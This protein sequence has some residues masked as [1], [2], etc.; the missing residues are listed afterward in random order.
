MV[1]QQHRVWRGKA[2]DER[3]SELSLRNLPTRALK[4]HTEKQQHHL[5]LV[6]A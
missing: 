1:D 3:E 5:K 6:I 4:A 2:N